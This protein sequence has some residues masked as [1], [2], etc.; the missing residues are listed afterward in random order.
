MPIWNESDCVLG[1]IGS[2]SDK[3][4]VFRGCDDDLVVIVVVVVLGIISRAQ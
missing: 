1:W 3:G 2:E 4:K